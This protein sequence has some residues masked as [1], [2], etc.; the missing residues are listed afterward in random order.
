MNDRTKAGRVLWRSAWRGL[1]AEQ[2]VTQV[3]F[4]GVPGVIPGYLIF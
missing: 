1:G 3:L 4:G 2:T